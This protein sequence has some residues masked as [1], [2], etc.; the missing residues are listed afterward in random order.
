MRKYIP[1]GLILSLAVAANVLAQPS[2]PKTNDL[3]TLQTSSA[4]ILIP[5][6]GTVQGANDT[7]FRS[8]INIINFRDADQRIE[9]RW[10]P[11]NTSGDAVP[12]RN[13]T[14]TARSGF[15][16]EDFVTNVL[17]ESGL[18]AIEVTGVTA[19][20]AFDQ[21]AQLHA[22]VR[23]WTPHPTAGGTMS[24]TFPAIA[25]ANNS[26]QTKWIFGVRR[27]SRYRLNVGVTN[28]AT[29]AQRYRVT[30]IGSAPPG[31]GETVEFDVP[32]RS[33]IQTSI[34]GG[35][36][37]AFQIVVQNISTNGLGTSWQTWASSIDNV[38]GDAWSQMGFPAPSGTP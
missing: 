20:G 25:L 2:T 15:F 24:Q 21:A 23:I 30:T 35:T 32:S 12:P 38:T 19:Q 33:M 27:D 8:D 9:L 29:V 18:G 13:I 26:I 10:L 34:P 31:T 14:V 6:A 5:V 36:G 1:I 11:Q 17:G 4:R 28:T 7:F 22:T 37:G 3:V 16:S